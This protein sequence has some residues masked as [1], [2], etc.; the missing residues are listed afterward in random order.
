MRRRRGTL[1]RAA[2]KDREAK[3]SGE[4]VMIVTAL[5]LILVA[6]NPFDKYDTQEKLSN[7]PHTLVISDGAA[8][9]RMDYK[10]GPLCAK[11]RDTIR[12]QVAPPPNGGGIIYG[13]SRTKAYCV[14]R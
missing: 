3:A 8:I 14:P 11:A 6:E 13:P 12:R 7:G 1:Q 10:T 5:M 4:I 9:T 2:E